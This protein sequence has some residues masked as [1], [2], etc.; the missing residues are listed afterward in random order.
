MNKYSIIH[1][2]FDK[3]FKD[4][5]DIS[6]FDE[7]LFIDCNKFT[8]LFIKEGIDKKLGI[9]Q[10]DISDNTKKKF[11]LV[12]YLFEN[13]DYSHL[14]S[15]IQNN[16]NDIILICSFVSE[17]INK[18]FLKENSYLCE[19]SQYNNLLSNLYE[20]KFNFLFLKKTDNP[21]MDS[22]LLIQSI[23]N[24]NVDKYTSIGYKDKSLQFYFKNI[25]LEIKQA[26]YEKKHLSYLRFG[27]GDFY[28]LRNLNFGS[29]KIGSRSVLKKINT[30]DLKLI[31]DSFWKTKN[32]CIE[33][34]YDS[35]NRIFF[36]VIFSYLDKSFFLNSAVRIL[37]LIRLFNFINKI[38]I[39][40]LT[41]NKLKF[42][43]KNF[44]F[45]GIMN[46]LIKKKLININRTDLISNFKNLNFTSFEAIYS[47]VSTRWVFKNFKNNN[48]AV[49]GNIE[50]INLIKKLSTNEE[51][52]NYLGVEKF[53]DF[54]TIPQK[55]STSNLDL[56]YELKEKIEKSK[57]DIFLFGIGSMKI[58]L[59]P[60]LKDINKVFID[61]GCGID[62]LAGV[63]SQDR[64]Y[65]SRW[66]N[67]QIENKSFENIDLMDQHNPMRFSK[68]YSTM[69]IKENDIKI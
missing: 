2:L 44:F 29:A 57:A 3:F 65:F 6:L 47:I 34:T 14:N 48:I 4:A 15:I 13:I 5:F 38:I 43:G 31:R 62:A 58:F 9:E 16:C 32:I 45:Y 1:S 63:V 53:A 19:W 23:C 36:E 22:S 68:K 61:V 66:V 17:K 20:K 40:I 37:K 51:Y 24:D 55:G 42:L 67:F 10:K 49:V 27:D 56:S 18:N 50:K 46:Y 59:F 28:L 30:S 39:L 11:D 21:H 69:Y 7:I 12:I 26:V 52:L 33:R 8:K 35:Y 25:L 54:I 60:L 41:S 64:P